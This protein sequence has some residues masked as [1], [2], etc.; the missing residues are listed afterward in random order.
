[1]SLADLR[2]KISYNNQEQ[3]IVRDFLTPSLK[4]AVEYNRAVGFFSSTALM[5]ATV[6]FKA[7]IENGGKIRIV[8]SPKLSQED[9]N[10]IKEGYEMREVIENSLNRDFLEPRN[11]FEEKRLNVLAYMIAHNFMEIKIAVMESDNP[12]EMFH[13][14]VGVIIDESGNYVTF[15][16]SMNESE[17]AYFG[18]AET[19]DV[20]TS[21]GSD[22]LRALEKK[23]YFDSLWQD[24]QTN[25]KVMNFPDSLMNKI[26]KFKTDLLDFD[27]DTKEFDNQFSAKKIKPKI[28]DFI[29]MRD[30]QI[31][32]YNNWKSFD[33]KG[34]YDMATGTG[35]TYTALY[36]MVELLKI[37]DQKLA[38]VICC[39]YQHLVLQWVDDLKEFGFNPIIAFSNSPQK[40]WKI[41]LENKVFNY[42]HDITDGFC[43]VTTNATFSTKF[44]QNQLSYI[45]KEFLIVIDEAHNFGTARLVS[46]LDDKYTFRLGLSAT[47]ERHNDLLGTSRLY[48]F[49]GNKCI[50]YTLDMAIKAGMLCQ[51]YYFPVVVN[52][53]FDEYDE[54]NKLS[55]QIVKYIKRNDD[56]SISYDKKAELLLIKRARLVAGAKMKLDKLEE[57]AKKYVNDNHLLVYC[58]ATTVVDNDYDYKHPSEDDLKQIDAVSK[59]LSNLGI[60]SSQFTSNENSETRQLL[61]EKFDDGSTLQALVAIRCLD[62]GVNIPSIDK[63]IILASSTNPK[64]YI[65]RRGRVLRKFKEKKYAIIYD[66]VTLPRS[67]DEAAGASCSN[68]DWGL[69][70]RELERVRDF[71]KSS[72]N[73]YISYDLIDKIEKTY[74]NVKE[75]YYD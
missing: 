27:L 11:D 58:G 74:S 29:K 37:K 3:N 2:F 12:F 40:K 15:T 68:Y 44:V 21:F 13:P 45:N 56:G 6:G 4:Q 62:E 23:N 25:V 69:I 41:N 72:L 35:K 55:A 47:L 43:L 63:A 50:E 70:N 65:Q 61:K 7:L 5:A 18:N 17:N 14:K 60:I 67:L 73:E 10:A 9:L 54:Y 39:P 34:I 51:Y 24:N 19:I 75:G 49:F 20:Y 28:P 36:S 64:E 1:M 66:F 48:D 32:A 31:E 57:V 8:C 33:F 59:I 16:G 26:F 22:Y 52:L 53:N 42:V 46:L 38:I 30:Y 71:A